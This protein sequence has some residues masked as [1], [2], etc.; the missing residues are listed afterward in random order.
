MTKSERRW[1]WL[2]GKKDV[3]MCVYC[4]HFHPHYVPSPKIGEY[5]EVDSGHC[6][7]PRPKL[8]MKYDL[9]EHFERKTK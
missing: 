5:I 1:A 3:D 4:K 7:H 2:A 9:C 8:R 6:C